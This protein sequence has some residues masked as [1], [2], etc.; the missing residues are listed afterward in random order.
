[1][2]GFFERLGRA[3]K[4]VAND[5]LDSMADPGRD[6]RQITRDLEEKITQAE[7]ALLDVR[8]EYELLRSKRGQAAKEVEKWDAAA[9]RAL[10][11]G[12]ESL[13][14]ECLAERKRAQKEL[15]GYAEQLGR[16]EPTVLEIEERLRGL[17][18]KKEE[19][20]RRADLIEART[21]VAESQEKA[22]KIL[23]GVGDESL[24]NDFQKLEDQAL[25]QEA[26]ANAASRMS[27]ERTGKSLEDRLQALGQSAIDD[28]LAALKK[29][30]GK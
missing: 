2:A 14:K 18:S 20:E 15:D 6:A 7:E 24:L 21:A 8:G 26:R 12:D 3:I 23:G 1:M 29:E 5:T 19:L 17:R 11:A 10:A 22:A 28:D 9:R 25:K 30:L 4:G 27:D 13:A 16:F